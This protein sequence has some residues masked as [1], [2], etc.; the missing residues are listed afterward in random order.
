MSETTSSKPPRKAPGDVLKSLLKE[1]GIL[2]AIFGALY[3]TGLHTE[4]FGRLQQLIL[5]TGLLSPRVDE[6]DLAPA[7]RTPAGELVV[8]SPSGQLLRLSELSG[9]VVFVNF[10]ATWCPPCIAEMPSIEALATSLKGN[11]EVESIRF[12]LVSLDEDPAIA[13]EFARRRKL[14]LPIYFLRSKDRRTFDSTQ[15]PTTYVISKSGEVV[16]ERRGMAKYDTR[17]FERFLTALAAEG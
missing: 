15:I 14:D 13:V 6:D 10:W 11:P 3:L 2:L 5:H 8:E 17:R 12:L 4:V 7:L 9:E 1:W 16:Y